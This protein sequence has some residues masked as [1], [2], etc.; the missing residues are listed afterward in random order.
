[1]NER[2][3][4]KK[5]VKNVGRNKDMDLDL[6]TYMYKKLYII[7]LDIIYFFTYP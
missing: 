2:G 7:I 1:M 5:E 6:Y 4:S 3:S